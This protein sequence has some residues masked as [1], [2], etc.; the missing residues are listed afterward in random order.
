[1]GHSVAIAEVRRKNRENEL[2]ESSP[3]W[4]YTRELTLGFRKLSLVFTKYITQF[5]PNVFFLSQ[6]SES[7]VKEL[8]LGLFE[9]ANPKSV[10]GR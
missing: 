6:E 10:Q 3:A 1:M 7:Y 4:F 8:M 9:V 2:W 5:L